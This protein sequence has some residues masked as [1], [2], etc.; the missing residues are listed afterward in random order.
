MNSKNHLNLLYRIFVANN[1]DARGKGYAAYYIGRHKNL[2]RKF[3]NEKKFEL[4]VKCRKKKE[5]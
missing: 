4:S 1:N 2:Q 3:S 5:E